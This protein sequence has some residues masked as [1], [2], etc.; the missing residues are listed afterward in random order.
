MYRSLAFLDH[1]VAAIDIWV[2]FGN[3]NFRKGAKHLLSEIQRRKTTGMGPLALTVQ[4]APSVS[5]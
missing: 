1:D 4:S 2:Q 3:E 5:I